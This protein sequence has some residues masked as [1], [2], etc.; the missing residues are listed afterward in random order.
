MCF[1]LAWF[2]NVLIWI[3]VVCAVIALLKLLVS[4]VLPKLGI[5]A[6]ILS[7]IVSAITIIIWAIICIFA[8]IF[9]FELIACLMGSGGIS[10][11][12]LG[13]GR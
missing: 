13:G 9:I 5:G 8:I 11:P 10:V 12:R 2:E 4:F 1:G 7:F 6:E 3:V